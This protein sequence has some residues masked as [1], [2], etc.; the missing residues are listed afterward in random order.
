M[1]SILLLFAF[2]SLTFLH[3][4]SFLGYEHSNYAGIV[5]ASY[6]PASLADNN[7][8]LDI[9]LIG[10]DVEGANNYVG[11]KRKDFGIPDWGTQNLYLRDGRNT[12]KAAFARAELLLPAFMVSNER[13]GWGIDMKIRTYADA[14]GI[15]PPLAHLL[16]RGLKDPADYQEFHNNHVGVNACSWFELGGT[17]AKVIWTGAEHF[18][19]IGFR[20]KF[21]LGLGAAY[22][23]VNDLEYQAYSDSTVGVFRSDVKFGHSDNFSFDEDFNPSYKIGFNP[24]FGIDAGMIYEFRPDDKQKDKKDKAKPWPGLRDEERPYWKYRMGISLTDLGIIHFHS[25]QYTDHYQANSNLWYINDSALSYTA[26]GPIYNNFTLG[27]AGSLSGKGLWM[28][29]PLA[30]DL[31]YDYHFTDHV[32]FNA[33]S[34]TGLYSRGTDF[35]KV[36]ELT[37]LSVTARYE[38]RW[39]GAW[40]PVSFTRMG[41]V[42][43]GAGGRIGPFIIGTTDVL[44]FML[45]N[46]KIYNA[47]LYFAI[48]VPLFPTGKFKTKK[49]KIKT[50]GPVDQCPA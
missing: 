16:A 9:L 3:A 49:G 50:G 27:N 43:V 44:N 10:A 32:Y 22:T 25:G 48:K 30:L 8:S 36:H 5:G 45:K 28:R 20:P 15:E 31:F 21:L 6:N 41:T 4:Q 33:Q 35:R 37:R 13:Y 40:I 19:S 24:G 18:V 42:S 17:Y 14:D 46:K 23:F 26:P 34:F 12:K 39:Y 11:I 29:T 7:Y 38:T 2:F 1:R 47:D